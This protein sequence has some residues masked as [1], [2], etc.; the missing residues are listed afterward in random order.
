MKQYRHNLAHL[1]LIAD[2]LGELLTEVTFVG[3]CTTILL[4]DKA[5]FGGVRQTDDVDVIVDVVSQLEYQQFSKRLRSKGFAEDREGPICRWKLK[6]GDG[7]IKLDV[8]PVSEEILGFSNR[9][10]SDVIASSNRHAL[11]SGVHI[12]V[13]SPGYFLAT[14]FEAFL[15]RG[16]GDYATSHD[17]EDIVFVLE[18]RSGLMKELIEYP[19]AVKTYLAQQ[20]RG[21]LN[22]EFLNVLPGLVTTSGGV[23]AVEGYLKLINRWADT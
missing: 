17:L 16:K 7:S 19:D 5:A 3:G 10:Y 4:V 15:G 1:E 9:W 20:A 11:T 23:K 21:L 18:N 6:T 8:M 14:K 12:N 2:A 13:V 22:D